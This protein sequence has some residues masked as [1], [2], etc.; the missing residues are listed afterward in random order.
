MLFAPITLVTGAD[1]LGVLPAIV[2]FNVLV[3]GPIALG[4]IYFIARRI[5][6]ELFGLW[7][8]ALWV[9]MPFAAIP[10][11]RQDYHVKYVELLLPQTFGL[12][13]MADFPSMVC[14]LVAGALIVRALDREAP[15]DWLLAGLAVGVA[16]GIKPSNAIFCVGAALAVLV[17]RRGTAVLPFLAGLA[18]AL[19]TLAVWKERGLGSVPLFAFEEVRLAVGTTLGAID[20][21][22][23]LGIDWDNLHTNMDGLREWF[24]SARLLQ[25]LPFAGLLAVARRSLPVSA[26]LAGWFGALLLLK[27]ST[28]LSTVESGSFFRYMMA[29]FPAYFLLAASIPLLIPRLAGRLDRLKQPSTGAALSTRAVVVIAV[30]VIALPLAAAGLPRPINS[31]QD[32]LLV[33]GILIPVDPDLKVTV[34]RHGE[35]RTITWNHPSTNGTSVFYRVFRT[36][37]GGPDTTCSTAKGAKRCDINLMIEL[38]TTRQR[39]YTDGSPPPATR[40]RIGIAANW[41]DDP[42]GGD[43]FAVSRPVEATP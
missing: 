1:F 37:L 32:A 5:G 19:L 26:L 30:A 3:L 20:L 42:E 40:F 9:V 21:H 12:T 36:G 31:S 27:G 25:W 38:A 15:T 17:A 22:R 23:Y 39:R 34:T 29:G 10:L 8:A 41:R 35:A 16:V 43:V 2:L 4:C 14:L 28:H 13:A 24:Y 11:F 6:G 18:P 33:N 7:S